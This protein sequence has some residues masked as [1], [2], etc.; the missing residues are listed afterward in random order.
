LPNFQVRPGLAISLGF[1]DSFDCVQFG[2]VDGQESFTNTYN[3]VYTGDGENGKPIERIEAAKDVTWKE[4]ELYF[5]NTV[6]P[7][8]G[9]LI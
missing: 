4:R 3:G 1:K 7:T 9:A 6:G 8:I 5:L 2:F